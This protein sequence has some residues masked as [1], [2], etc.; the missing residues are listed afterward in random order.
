MVPKYLLGT[1]AHSGAYIQASS[2]QF[3]HN[4]ATEVSG[5]PGRNNRV[6]TSSWP[7]FRNVRNGLSTKNGGDFSNRIELK[8]DLLAW[9]G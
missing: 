1:G 2:K 5:C 9:R 8:P 4:D 3:A 7:R 6:S